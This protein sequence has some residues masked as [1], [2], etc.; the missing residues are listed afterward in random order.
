MFKKI[1][2][3]LNCLFIKLLHTSVTDG[4]R[5]V[6]IV[7]GIDKLSDKD[8][9]N[10]NMEDNPIPDRISGPESLYFLRG[11]CFSKSVERFEYSFC[12]FNN[13]TQRRIIGQRSTIIGVWG[14][15]ITIDVNVN[16]ELLDSKS[17]H[18]ETSSLRSNNASRALSGRRRFSEMVYSDGQGCGESGFFSATARMNCGS[19][20]RQ[21]FISKIEEVTACSFRIEMEIPLPCSL[22][23]I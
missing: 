11:F 16:E 5:E 8:Q 18:P 19:G 12:P 10:Y 7:E 22:F 13:V 14:K 3:L 4:W 23:V 15:W 2:F 20:G 1:I 9:S 6:R 21:F 17:L